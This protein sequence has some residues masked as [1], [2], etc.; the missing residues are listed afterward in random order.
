MA[1]IVWGGSTRPTF[2]LG[3]TEHKLNYHVLDNKVTDTNSSATISSDG[4]TVINGAVG[5]SAGSTTLYSGFAAPITGVRKDII[6]KS[7]TEKVQL[8]LGVPIAA[9]NNP[10]VVTFSTQG[11]PAALHLI[12]LSTAL[13]GIVGSQGTITLSS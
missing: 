10:T 8:N 11:N 4:V 12:G 2:F 13:W 3:S 7:S 1:S 6:I 5:S 9:V